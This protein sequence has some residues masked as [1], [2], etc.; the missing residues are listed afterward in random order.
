MDW[1]EK[2]TGF[3]ETDYAQT[4]AQLEVIGDRLHSR[5][6][7]ASYGIGRFELVS[8]QALRERAL[9]APALPGRMT[10]SVIR[11]DV[12]QMHRLPANA[13]ALFQVASQFNMLEMAGPGI[14]P[15]DGVTRY[16]NDLTQG[17]ACAIAAGAATIY[18]NY[19]A[20]VDGVCGQ[21]KSRQID[22]LAG[23]G[24]ALSVGTGL[25]VG[26]LWTMRNGYAMATQ[27]G[28]AAITR[29]LE[30]L[31]ADQVDTL[32]GALSIGL[33]HDVEATE[34][35]RPQRH[36][37]SQAFCSALP[38]GYSEVA[39]GHWRFFA[40]LVLEAAYEAT[41]WAGV[42]NARH[43]ASNLVFLTLV[44]GGAFGNSTD[45]IHCAVRRAL[46]MMRPYGLDVRLVS[47]G[48]PSGDLVS[49]AQELS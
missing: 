18:R 43:G 4:R 26:A 27:E 7:G 44:G 30:T 28:L 38:V 14:T 40:S 45:W 47:Y 17:P 33:H 21:T 12:R 5:V 1:F 49:L 34:A 6:N 36:H 13:G 31:S 41:M 19:F 16:R 48:E 20:P 3:R 29:H 39:A 11:G 2:L 9:S 42:L 10:V 23:L 22:G 32:R 8:L 46:E 37:V 25:P 35:E 24:A 15:E